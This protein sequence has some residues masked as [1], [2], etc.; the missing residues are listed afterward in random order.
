M[1]IPEQTINT[2]S[3]TTPLSAVIAIIDA[4]WKHQQGTS[5]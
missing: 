5:I 1:Q 2:A 4:V 3:M